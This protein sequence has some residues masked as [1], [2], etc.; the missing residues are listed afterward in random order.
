MLLILFI[1]GGGTWFLNPSSTGA[2]AA[3][4]RVNF[5]TFSVFSL[6]FFSGTKAEIFN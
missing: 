4:P 3:R 5:D 1:F 6:F 2:D